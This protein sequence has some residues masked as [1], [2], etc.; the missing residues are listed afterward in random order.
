VERDQ[1]FQFLTCGQCARYVPGVQG[2]GITRSSDPDDH[3]CWLRELA[4]Q[5]RLGAN[6]HLGNEVDDGSVVSRR[7]RG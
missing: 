6:E 7:R 4:P 2:L 3:V 1:F 5:Q